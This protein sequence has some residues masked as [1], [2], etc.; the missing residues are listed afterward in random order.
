MF[1]AFDFKYI[2]ALAGIISAEPEP[3]RTK[4]N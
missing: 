1:D 2:G 4:L 3:I